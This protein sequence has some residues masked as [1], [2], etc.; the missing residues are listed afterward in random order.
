MLYYD[1]ELN[2][3]ILDGSIVEEKS[4]M[5]LTYEEKR[6]RVQEFRP[7][8]DTFFEVFANDVD[9]CQE[10]LRVILQDPN[11]EVSSVSVQA[12]YKNMIGRSVRLDALC[13]LGDGSVCNIEVQRAD[14]DDHLRRAR[15]HAACLTAGITDPGER[16]K[17][18]PTLYIVYITEFDFLQ[19]NRTIYH[20]DRMIRETDTVVD[21]GQH[22]IF[23]NTK[24]NDGSEIAEL[25]QCF[26][27]KEVKNSKFPIFSNRVQ[28]LKNDE[29]GL[30]VM[31]EVMEKYAKEYVEKEKDDDIRAALKKGIEI[32]TI[33][34]VLRVTRGRVE[35]VRK[36]MMIH[37]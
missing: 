23:V 29:G 37:N 6:R 5:K 36:D 17:E 9:V 15:Y 32:E 19:Q 21:D 11:M 24:V 30:S 18:V 7:I 34:E 22:E 2:M 14:H 31:C 33:C 12:N 26:M 16:F 4:S 3:I 35:R 8:D 20:I 25:M 28:Y 10:I 27:Q 13:T 1:K